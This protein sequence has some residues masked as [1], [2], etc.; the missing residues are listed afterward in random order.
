MARHDHSEPVTQVTQPECQ[1]PVPVGAAGLGWPGQLD[2]MPVITGRGPVTPRRRRLGD[3]DWS[4]RPTG[5][6]RRVTRYSESRVTLTAAAAPGP[7]P[8]GPAGG[9]PRQP[10]CCQP[11]GLGLC[12]DVLARSPGRVPFRRRRRLGA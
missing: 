4:R 2:L 6:V 3:S 1:L 7:P 10:G 8:P 9:L 12:P 5:T 11:E